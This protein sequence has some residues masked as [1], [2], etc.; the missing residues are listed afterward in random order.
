M[1]ISWELLLQRTVKLSDITALLHLPAS[2]SSHGDA[3][4]H[5][6]FLREEGLFPGAALAGEAVP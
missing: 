5:L 3:G 1:G 2:P 4:E 6:S